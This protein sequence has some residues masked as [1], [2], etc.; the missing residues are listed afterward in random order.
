M[1][2]AVC[3]QRGR[4]LAVISPGCA[5]PCAFALLLGCRAGFARTPVAFESIDRARCFR[6]GHGQLSDQALLPG[7]GIATAK[8]LN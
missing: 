5:L 8:L 1:R 3:Q 2:H 6:A 7:V 4:Q